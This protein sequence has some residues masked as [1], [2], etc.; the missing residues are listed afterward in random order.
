MTEQPAYSPVNELVLAQG[1]L[2]G[3]TFEQRVAAAAAGGFTAIGLSL[4][5]YD[6]LRAAGTTDEEMLCILAVYGIRVAELDGLHGFAAAKNQP[7]VRVGSS[8][9]QDDQTLERLLDLADLFHARLLQV[10]GTSHTDKLEDDAVEKFQD[11]CD[12]A[13]QRR[14]EVSLEPRINTNIASIRTAAMIVSRAQRRN[15]GLC[16]TTGPHFRAKNAAADLLAVPVDLV[17]AIRLSHEV[18][19]PGALDFTSSAVED[20]RGAVEEDLELVTFLQTIVQHG[21]SVTFSERH[22]IPSEPNGSLCLLCPT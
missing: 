2:T 12:Q 7:G 1:S 5:E 18:T 10:F 4:Y 3:V 8:K 20:G 17:S 6:R 16:I 15:A 14:L 9:A 22:L 11:I 19:A 21:V 13:A